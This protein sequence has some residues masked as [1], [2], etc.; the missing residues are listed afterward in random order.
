MHASAFPENEPV[1]RI[2]YIEDEPINGVLMQSWAAQFPGLTMEL[3]VTGM[4]GVAAC[5][6]EAPDAVL[7]DMHL[8]DLHGLEVLRRIRD[9]PALASLP[10]IML[11]ASNSSEHVQAALQAG[12]S[13]YWLKPVDF[14]QM[15]QGLVDLMTGSRRPP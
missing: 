15:E 1:G 12:A 11:S 4:T 3:A 14:K 10:V 8:P 13:A 9:V 5:L 7:L 2:V 6:R